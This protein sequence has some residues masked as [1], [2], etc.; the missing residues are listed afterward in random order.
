MKNR[1][2]LSTVVGMVFAIIA[3]TTTVVYVSYSMNLLGQYNNTVL[4]KNQALADV[5]KEKFQIANV[6]VA[7]SKLNVTLANTGTLP[8]NFTKI[9]IQN[10]TATDWVRSYTQ[11]NSFVSPGA[12]LTNLGQGIPVYINSADSYN[13]KLVTSR[14]NTQTFTV[15]SVSSTPIY[16][17]LLTLPPSVPSGSSTELELLVT[18]NSTGVLVNVTP[19]TPQLST[20]STASSCTVGSLNPSSY[21]TLSAGATAVFTWPLT[22][23]GNTGTTCSYI[24]Q[25]QNSNQISPTATVT[26]SVNAVSSTQ[27]SQYAGLLTF[28]YTTFEWNQGAGWQSGWAGLLHNVPT[29]FKVNVTNNDY[30]AS[31][32]VVVSLMNMATTSGTL[33]SSPYQITLSNF[34]AGSGTNRILIVGVSGVGGTTVSSVTFAGTPLQQ[35]VGKHDSYDSELWYLVQPTGSGD[36]VVTMQNSDYVVVGAYAFSGVDQTTPI[37]TV[38]KANNNPSSP[39]IS[40]TTQYPGSWVLDLPSISGSTTLSGSGCGT[41]QWNLHDSQNQITGASS[42]K[43]VTT[44]NQV[45][46]SWID[47]TGHWDDVAIELKA[48]GSVSS[49]FSVSS[50][51]QMDFIYL[52]NGASQITQFFIV[53]ATSTTNNLVEYTCTGGDYCIS[54]AP[55]QTVTLYFSATQQQQYGNNAN[56]LGSSNSQ[57]SGSIIMFGKFGSQSYA[58][59]IPSIGLS[60]T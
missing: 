31:G 59:T 46:C 58:Q 57:Y 50:L 54:I 20:S 56:N 55:G 4:A 5:N 17:Q 9:W 14:G 27:F 34:N 36:I 28:N 22:I 18:N 41:V 11:T 15:N 43:L 48:V 16:L 2:A 7:N 60:V 40:I 47:A 6:A 53:N 45:T 39:S 3:F 25:L 37:P 29:M 52:K 35:A 32:N 24:V 21:K 23:T 49:T 1:R 12:T 10:T 44:P 26:V 30:S 8:I 42:T 13:V 51:S 33:S 19:Q 38:A